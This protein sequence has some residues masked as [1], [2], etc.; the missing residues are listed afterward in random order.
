M[1]DSGMWPMHNL[2]QPRNHVQKA[3]TVQ[4]L[5]TNFHLYCVDIVSMLCSI[6]YLLSTGH[7]YPA[8]A[9]TGSEQPGAGVSRK[10]AGRAVGLIVIVYQCDEVQ[11]TVLLPE[12]GVSHGS[13][14][15]PVRLQ[16]HDASNLNKSYVRTSL[17]L[18]IV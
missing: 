13:W 12:K 11:G 9:S 5:E 7:S 17:M 18:S 6:Y 16:I 15:C 1:S 4:A 3:E 8:T 14:F 2:C 10:G